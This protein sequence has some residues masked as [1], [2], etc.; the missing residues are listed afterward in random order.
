MKDPVESNLQAASTPRA[1]ARRRLY[2]H[3]GFII[4]AVGLAIVLG[5]A[6]FAPLLAPY[7]PYEQV[8]TRRLIPPFWHDDGTWLFP[9]GTDHLGRDYL[10]RILYG[11]RVSLAIGF[12][13]T[14]I[15]AVIGGTLGMAA[16]YFGGRVDMVVLFMLSTRLSMPVVLVALS[17][18]ALVGGSLTV[19]ISV[20]G[21][22]LWDRFT[23]VLR[24]V[25]M[26]ERLLDYVSAAKAIGCTDFRIIAREIFPNVFPAFVVIA[27]LE[28]ANA[29]LLE[30]ALSFL[31]LG[32]QPPLPSWGLMIAEAKEQM[33]FSP[34]I[35]A[36]PGCALFALVLSINL[37][38]D[39]LRDVLSPEGRN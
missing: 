34:W 29:I 26:R 38:G 12:V 8:L 1:M 22:L 33:Y 39:G 17:V 20:L 3:K 37:F 14:I 11:A 9:L 32:V 13:A 2:Q 35:I 15:S 10:S 30:A 36:I 6:L 23:V 24:A 18:V 31:G 21:C 19:V 5:M 4:G 25:T 7:D 28:M 27:T 16:G